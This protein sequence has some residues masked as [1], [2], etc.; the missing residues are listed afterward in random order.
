MSSY[1]DLS[2]LLE[3]YSQQTVAGCGCALAKG[4]ETLYE[5]YTGFADKENGKPF[6]PD[7]VCRL[8]S[9]TKLITVTAAMILFERGKFLLTDPLSEYFPE[10]A[11]PSV[12]HTRMDGRV[13]V[14]KAKKPL[15]VKHAFAMQCGLPYPDDTSLTGRSMLQVRKE[16]EETYGKYDLRTEI[17]AMSK[18]PLAFE[19]GE[20]FLYGFGH[21]LVAGL[22]EVVSGKS[23][24]Q[25]MKEEIFEPL[26][27]TSTGYRHFGDTRDRM[28]VVYTKTP[29]GV[30]YPS[31]NQFDAT[32]EPDAVYEG[33]G[34]GLFSTVRDYLRFTQMLACGGQWKGQKIIGR[35]TINLMRRDQLTP[36]QKQENFHGCYLD[37]YGY[38]L[39]VRTMVDPAFGTSNSP[40]GEFGWTGVLGTWTSIYPEEQFSAVYMHQMDPNEEEYHHL[41]VRTVAYGTL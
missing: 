33:G 30:L 1:T 38:G 36:A 4:G 8:Y 6:G 9:L 19:P 7:T 35:H 27:M 18:V 22:I 31:P 13:Y 32:H 2:N 34:A 23:V 21:D 39:G 37:G 3:Q 5:M 25:F 28:A 17:K 14:E 20:H 10:Y 12:A 16:L 41:R 24:G 11:S 26:G 29:E 15:L 40:V